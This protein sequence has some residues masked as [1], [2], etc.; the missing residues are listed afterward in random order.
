MNREEHKKDNQ[1]GEKR[2]HDEKKGISME[3]KRLVR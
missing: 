3:G 2:K 1:K